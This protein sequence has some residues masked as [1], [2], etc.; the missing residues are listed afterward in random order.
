MLSLNA[1][2][3]DNSLVEMDPEK[4]EAMERKNRLLRIAKLR[5]MK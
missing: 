1:E 2:N 4:L 5:Q 3:L